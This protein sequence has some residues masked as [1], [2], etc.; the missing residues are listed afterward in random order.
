ML[1]KVTAAVAMLALS[2]GVAFAEE[3][4]IKFTLG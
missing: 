2:A 3:T 1:R 4:T